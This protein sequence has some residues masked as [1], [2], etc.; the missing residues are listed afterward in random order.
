[1]GYTRE[2]LL[3]P[4]FDFISIIAPHSRPLILHNFEKHLRGE[5]VPPCEYTLIG[6][7]GRIIP[8]FYI[9]RLIQY[10]GRPAILGTVTDI[11]D[12]KRAEEETQKLQEQ[13]YEAQKMKAIAALAGGVAHDFNNM[14]TAI[15]GFASLARSELETDSPIADYM[16]QIADVSKKASELTTQLLLFSRKKKSE[17]VLC[18]IN[19]TIEGF[20]KMLERLVYPAVSI[21]A[22]FSSDLWAVRADERRV[23]QVVM[24]LVMNARDA[25]PKGGTIT[26]RTFNRAL[27][28]SEASAI[29]EASPGQYACISVADTGVGISPENIK[30]IFEPF[31]TTK[32]QGQ[33]TG[34][35]LAVVYGIVRQHNGCIQVQSDPGKGAVFTVF[36]PAAE[37]AIGISSAPPAQPPAAAAHCVLVIEDNE[38]IR[39]FAATSLRKHGY[40]VREAAL[41]AAALALLDEGTCDFDIALIDVTLPDYDGIELAKKL[42][43]SRPSLKVLFTSGYYNEDLHAGYLKEHGYSL[44]H[45]PFDMKALIDGIGALAGS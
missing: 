39:L 17:F 14:I 3:S 30:R 12:K 23:E 25:M 11:T 10:D 32:Q 28:A 44:L 41:G 36:I 29:A 7:G 37:E 33:G 19:T 31:F 27:S 1:M 34:L 26:L 5:D 42:L 2:E 8:A 43:S 6:K 15:R 40:R 38:S 45:K 4:G 21:A 13:L 35:G 22:E 16:E 9:T 24:N 18:N 20:L